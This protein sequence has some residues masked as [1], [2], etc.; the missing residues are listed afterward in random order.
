MLCVLLLL[1]V[2]WLLPQ[3]F[4]TTLLLILFILI[5]GYICK[6]TCIVSKETSV[7]SSSSPSCTGGAAGN[8]ILQQYAY[9]L[10]M[11]L[12]SDNEF[13]GW[14]DVR[15]A[16]ETVVEVV[17]VPGHLLSAACKYIIKFLSQCVIKEK[18]KYP[19]FFTVWF[20]AEDD[21]NGIMQFFTRKCSSTTTS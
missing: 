2:V 8:I 19:G 10:W 16:A 15:A 9:L 12:W 18:S 7:I 17:P 13:L 4:T 5:Y 20:L 11:M 6:Y 21:D 1:L 14:R 3:K